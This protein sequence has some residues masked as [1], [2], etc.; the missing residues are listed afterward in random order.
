M[1]DKKTIGLTE[2]GRRRIAAIMETGLFD[3]QIHIAKVAASLALRAK[4][5]LSDCEGAETTWNVGSFD[6]DSDFR[7]LIPLIYGSDVMPYRTLEFLIDAGLKN[8]EQE[9]AKDAEANFI[10]ML[11]AVE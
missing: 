9:L 3:D 7:L 4:V 6:P 1:S 5:P 10:K 8:L 2:G 11:S